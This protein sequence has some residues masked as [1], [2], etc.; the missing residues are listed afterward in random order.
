MIS[1]TP[2]TQAELGLTSRKSASAS[3]VEKA[4]QGGGTPES[5]AS[6][7]ARWNPSRW[8]GTSAADL[9]E[10]TDLPDKIKL[11]I[12]RVIKKSRLWRRE[13]ME[14]ANE[15]LGHFEDGIRSGKEA[16][17]LI[18]DF[19]DPTV[20]AQL[21]RSSKIRN[22]SMTTKLLY[23]GLWGFLAFVLSYFGLTAFYHA[24]KANPTH[25]YYAE[26]NQPALSVPEAEAA[27]PIYR[28]P[29]AKFG[30][31]EG[32]GGKFNEIYIDRG[33][34]VRD[35]VTPEDGE[36]WQAAFN[37]LE[38]SAELL[39]AFRAARAKSH[40]GLALYA[41]ARTYSDEDFAALF[42]DRKRD[43]REYPSLF[44]QGQN[45]I[46]DQSM[47]GILLPHYQIFRTATR[48]LIVDTRWAIEQ[49]DF[50]RV[51][52]NVE[53]I[54][55]FSR[56][57][58]NELILVGDLVA[59][60][61][62][63]MGADLIDELLPEYL[64]QFSDEQLARMQDAITQSDPAKFLDLSGERM[65][66][67]DILQRC[68]TDDGNGD[69]RITSSGY[70]LIKNFNSLFGNQ[71]KEAGFETKLTDTFQTL[72]APIA[73]M[74]FPSRKQVEVEYVAYL[75]E[76]EREMKKP[77]FGAAKFK[78]DSTPEKESNPFIQAL[79]PGLQAIG[80]ATF[81]TKGQQEA[82]FAAIAVYR[83]QKRNGSLPKSLAELKDEYLHDLPIDQFD[84][85]P[86]RYQRKDDGFI[87]YSIGYDRADDGGN[88]KLIE[89][90]PHDLP[91]PT[92]QFEMFGKDKGLDWVLWP[93]MSK[94]SN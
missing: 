12:L 30:F 86:L 55:G 1:P 26:F 79:F 94:T 54:F 31:S 71:L 82:T 28:Q 18:H 45:E 6:E 57:L 52:Q 69:G 60:A 4:E 53:A 70:Q 83:F 17:K 75:D 36:A 68:F 42:P 35:L 61:I 84:G 25:D 47:I 90:L 46:L 40:L 91:E 92:S 39:N 11:T 7:P 9:I 81:R 87:L 3:P 63:S 37:K 15:L 74:Q 48:V 32:G 27:W 62:Q 22:R 93:R 65:M 58:G 73:M 5:L 56:Q 85:Q 50:E 33:E 43:D 24:G 20:A 41:D 14:V 8:F 76:N 13:K 78:S 16:E 34:N 21:I 66:A 77:Y 44:T 23:G 67:L 2:S 29:F 49:N 10:Q 19:G 64:N 80:R 72:A 38:E 59:F 51:T 89:S 88:R